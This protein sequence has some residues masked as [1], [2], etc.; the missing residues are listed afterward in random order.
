VSNTGTRRR[1]RSATRKSR[2]RRDEIMAAAKKCLP[3]RVFM[4]HHHRGY[5]QTG[6][7]AYGLIYWYFESKDELFMP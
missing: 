5:R 7:L 4:P 6:R 1:G 3:A 2:Q